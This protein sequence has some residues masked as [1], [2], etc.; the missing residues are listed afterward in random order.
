M[1]ALFGAR[2]TMPALWLQA[3]SAG[4][5]QVRGGAYRV[6]QHL[7]AFYATCARVTMLSAGHEVKRNRQK[8]LLDYDQ[9]QE[10][11]CGAAGPQRRQSFC[12]KAHS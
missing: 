9:E 12:R 10:L 4:R 1:L 8:R 7:L 11:C 2:I 6:R 3:A 5:A